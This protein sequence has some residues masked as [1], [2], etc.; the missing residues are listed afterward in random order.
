MEALERR[1][2]HAARKRAAVAVARKLAI[3]FKDGAAYLFKGDLAEGGDVAAF[4]A[5]FRATGRH[6]DFPGFF[7]AY[8]EGSDEYTSSLDGSP[9]LTIDPRARRATVSDIVAGPVRRCS[10]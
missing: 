8:V 9:Q 4:D 2:G 5:E 3:V 6:V 1:G 7:R 10:R